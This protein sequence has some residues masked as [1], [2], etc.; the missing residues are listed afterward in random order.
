VVPVMLPFLDVY[1]KALAL[2]ITSEMATFVAHEYDRVRTAASL[3][4]PFLKEKRK[5]ERKK[6]PHFC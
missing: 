3:L 4:C 6:R 1:A 2:T 5:K